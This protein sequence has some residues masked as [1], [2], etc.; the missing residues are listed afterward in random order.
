MYNPSPTP[1]RYTSRPE[2]RNNLRHPTGSFGDQRNLNTNPREKFIPKEYY[3]NAKNV[4]ELLGE[5]K[6]LNKQLYESQCEK[7]RINDRFQQCQNKL[8]KYHELAS[9]YKEERDELSMRLYGR[10]I[11]GSGEDNV[12]D[13]SEMER[14]LSRKNIHNDKIYVTKRRNE[15]AESRSQNSSTDDK[16][17]KTQMDDD[18]IEEFALKLLEKIVAVKKEESE[19]ASNGKKA[20]KNNSTDYTDENDDDIIKS[21]ELEELEEKVSEFRNKLAKRKA[22]GR[23][24]A[25]LKLELLQ[26][27]QELGSSNGDS[28]G[29]HENNATGTEKEKENNLGKYRPRRKAKSRRGLDDFET[30]YDNMLLSDQD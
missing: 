11:Y 3:E 30:E 19:P 10:N 4:D 14:E 22:L 20:H 26:L 6:S 27:Q 13:D 5:I 21:N 12:L 1:R 15:D 2:F 7:I 29:S 18:K 9:K 8:G 28:N 24:K 17:S 16:D 25:S 23:R